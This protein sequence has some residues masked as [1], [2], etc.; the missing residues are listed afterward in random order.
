MVFQQKPWLTSSVRMFYRMFTFAVIMLESLGRGESKA[1]WTG[2][3][4][5]KV[6]P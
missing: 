1:E 6:I 5:I 2:K 3:E 4:V